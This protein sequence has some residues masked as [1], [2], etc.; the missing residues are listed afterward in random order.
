MKPSEPY[1]VRLEMAEMHDTFLTNLNQAM[2][3]KG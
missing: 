1:E 2:K 3:K